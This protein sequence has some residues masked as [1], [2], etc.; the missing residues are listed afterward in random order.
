MRHGKVHPFNVT[1]GLYGRP[2]LGI[3]GD[4]VSGVVC[5]TG[6]G[7]AA[8]ATLLTDVAVT[9]AAIEPKPAPSPLK[10]FLLVFIAFP[11]LYFYVVRCLSELTK[12]VVPAYAGM[13]VQKMVVVHRSLFCQHFFT[14]ANQALSIYIATCNALCYLYQNYSGQQCAYAG[15]MLKKIFGTLLAINFRGTSKQLF[16]TG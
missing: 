3:N 6:S 16:F 7:K 15:T 5:V 11:F 10:K 4:M 8:I 14:S 2:V 13:T 9:A 1:T 12:L